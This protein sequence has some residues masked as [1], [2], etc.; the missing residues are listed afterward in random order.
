ML[1][2]V[3]LAALLAV[4]VWTATL[5]P[6]LIPRASEDWSRGQILG[7]TPVSRPPA[8]RPAPDGGIFLVWSTLAGELQLVHIDGTGEIDLEETLPVD[9][10]NARDPQM[11]IDPA[12]QLHLLWRD[13]GTTPA[14]I[15][16]ATVTADGR[17]VGS[18]RVLSQG[19]GMVADMP[20]LV[21]DGDD[22]LHALWAN[23]TGIQHAVLSLDGSLVSDPTPVVPDGRNPAAR[24]DAAGQLQL[25]WQQ[26]GQG[27]GIL[28][29]HATYTPQDATWSEPQELGQVFL[30][31][32]QRLDGP[33]LGM[34]TETGYAVWS[35]DDRRTAASLASYATFPLDGSGAP[36]IEDLDVMRGW[37]PSDVAP[38]DTP[39]EPLWA[40]LSEVSPEAVPTML[41]ETLFRSN[42]ASAAKPQITLVDL[43][44]PERPEEIITASRQASVSPNLIRDDAGHLH[45]TALEVA[46][47]D[48]YRVIYA[49]TAPGVLETYNAVT[50]YDVVDTVMS[51]LLQSSL[52]VLAVIPMLFLWVVVPM[53]CLIV[54]HWFSGAEEL[55][56]PGPRLALALI[57]LLELGL[58][59]AFP[60]QV[61]TAW[62]PFRWVGPIVTAAIAGG[63]T[64]LLLRRKE[65]NTLFLAF[66]AYTGIHVLLLWLAYF[67]V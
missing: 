21:I 11:V 25:V 49:S 8:I 23:A 18:P 33:S 45:L 63:L 47:T 24:F 41:L 16:H 55:D 30:R 35:I 52:F 65:E 34:T 36:Q 3:G 15:R 56:R 6:S 28:I 43:S 61:E 31:T 5:R 14:E 53:L 44:R 58:T 10:D 66:F 42:D 67:L 20:Q 62:P 46:G 12:G 57:L 2:I 22:R 9:T 64:W 13:E 50:V 19:E 1:L 29:Y 4:I 54:Y 60:L 59:L 37:N 40:A 48:R 26:T 38:I 32:A 27:R 51:G 7:Q 39:Q 17:A